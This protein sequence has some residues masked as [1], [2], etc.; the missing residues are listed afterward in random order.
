MNRIL[1]VSRFTFRELIRSNMLFIWLVSVVVL[2][3]LAFL[4]SILSFG[5]ILQIFMDLGLTGMEISGLLV[6]LLGLAVTYTTEMDQKAIYLHLAKPLTRGEYLLGRILGFY[7]VI[8]LVVLGMGL[9]VFGLVVTAGGQV[10]ALFYDCVLFILLEMFVLTVVGLTYQMI[11]TSMV[12]VFLYAFFTIFLGHCIGVVE[13]L[14]NQELSHWVKTMLK[15]IYYLLPNLEAFNL[16]DRIYDP[17]LVL[18]PAQWEE[19]L[20]YAFAYSFVAFLIGWVNLEK[21]EFK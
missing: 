7:A 21:R 19:I 15:V 12:A 10:P 5:S 16:K 9:V 20:L 18:G 2:C 13:W 1:A 6:L 3:G 11:A 14:L 17:N 4:L 8:S